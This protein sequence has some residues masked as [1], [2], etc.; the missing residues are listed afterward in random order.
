MHR[1]PV[2]SALRLLTADDHPAYGECGRCN[3]RDGLR[4]ELTVVSLLASE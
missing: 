1:L 4:N 2:L 3:D